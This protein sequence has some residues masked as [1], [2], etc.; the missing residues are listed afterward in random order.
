MMQEYLQTQ[1]L[2]HIF[3]LGRYQGVKRLLC[4]ASLL[5]LYVSLVMQ[6]SGGSNTAEQ[7]FSYRLSSAR[8]P[9]ECAFGRLKGRFAALRRPMDIKLDAL[10]FVIHA[11]FI[12][13][14]ICELKNEFLHENI[15]QLSINHENNN[16]PLCS[17][18]N[19][20]SST[21]EEDGKKIRHFL[22]ST[23]SDR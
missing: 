11:C 8:M 15:V 10:P 1:T 5:S 16:Q 13:H 2:I 12:L 17:S 4:L 7:F 9:I 3:E 18:F 20:N 19:S 14:N 21:A 6:P 22:L 23:L